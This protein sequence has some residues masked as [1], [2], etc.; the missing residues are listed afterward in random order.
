LHSQGWQVRVQRYALMLAT[1]VQSRLAGWSSKVLFRYSCCK[2]GSASSQNLCCNV[3]CATMR[4]SRLA[5]WSSKVLFC[6]SCCKGGSASSQDLCCNVICATMRQSRLAVGV[7]TVA[8]AK[9]E[10]SLVLHKTCVVTFCISGSV[11]GK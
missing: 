4:Q 8:V 9:I 2:G 3:L 11:L 5:G 6:Y 10:V 7:L 1:S